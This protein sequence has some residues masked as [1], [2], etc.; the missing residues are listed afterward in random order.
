MVVGDLKGIFIPNEVGSQPVAHYQRGFQQ[1]EVPSP[2]LPQE[3][4]EEKITQSFLE[5]EQVKK[6]FHRIKWRAGLLGFALFSVFSFKLFRYRSLGFMMFLAVPLALLVLMATSMP[7]Q[8]DRRW[9]ELEEKKDA[10]LFVLAQAPPD[11]V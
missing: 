11:V 4:I 8:Y 9:R 6:Q 10:L 3:T 7:T 1:S 5:I 2:S